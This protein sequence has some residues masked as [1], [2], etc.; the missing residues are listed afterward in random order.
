MQE[1]ARPANAVVKT[2]FYGIVSM[3][4]LALAISGF[5]YTYF[6]PMITRGF[7]HTNPF[8]HW[9]AVSAVLWL[10]L[11]CVQTHLIANHQ[12]RLHMSLG[13]FGV[14]V[15]VLFWFTGLATATQAAHYAVNSGDPELLA[16]M[17]ALHIAPTVDLI[18]FALFVGFAVRL[19]RRGDI[20]K[21]L[22]FLASCV[23]VPPST[24]RFIQWFTQGPPSE[25]QGMFIPLVTT[26]FLLAGPVYDKLSQGH[27]HKVYWYALPYW[28][29]MAAGIPLATETRFW[30]PVVHWIGSF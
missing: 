22:M 20:H 23:F 18:A 4:I 3:L 17:E 28:V 16:F 24:F 9:H 29:C 6:H 13:M 14:G 2:S 11:Y 27:A 1:L 30:A 10:L 26:A 19:R 12:P 7:T 15:A 21:R 25:A 8:I 5:S